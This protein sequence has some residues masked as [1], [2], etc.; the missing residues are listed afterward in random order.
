MVKNV[1]KVLDSILSLIAK[2]GCSETAMDPALKVAREI[3]GM[4]G[5]FQG[6][7]TALTENE[8]IYVFHFS[9]GQIIGC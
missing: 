9:D 6:P 3:Q 8:N 2:P 5:F 1:E 7:E 4:C